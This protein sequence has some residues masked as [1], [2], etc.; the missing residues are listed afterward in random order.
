MKRLIGLVIVVAVAAAAYAAWGLAAPSS[1][2]RETA[3]AAAPKLPP[4]PAAVKQRKRWLVGVKCDAPPFGFI[5][6]RGRNAG[7][8][9]EIA[10]WFARYAFGRETRVSFT[11]APTPT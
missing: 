1:S 7:F 2:A 11:C 9:I 5:D 3:P 4:L 6:V 8:D 10:R